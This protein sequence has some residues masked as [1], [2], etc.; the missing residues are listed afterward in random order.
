MRKQIKTIKIEEFEYIP[1]SHKNDPDLDITSS[2]ISKRPMVFVGRH[3]SKDE[4]YKAKDLI[5][6]KGRETLS[7]EEIESLRD[8]DSNPEKATSAMLKIKRVNEYEFTK[9]VFLT[10]CKQIKNVLMD[11]KVIEVMEKKDIAKLLNTYGAD[12]EIETFCSYIFNQS[13]LSESEAKK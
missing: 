2:D 13:G 4:Y 11:D 12:A 6:V 7:K 9:Y 5:E 8:F 3:L 1:D 10:A